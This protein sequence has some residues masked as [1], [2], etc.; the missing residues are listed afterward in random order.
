MPSVEP[1]G[2]YA[3]GGRCDTSRTV[4][5]RHLVPTWWPTPAGCDGL[6]CF[7]TVA[8]DRDW[9]GAPDDT[10]VD[11]DQSESVGSAPA[12]QFNAG[13][14]QPLPSNLSGGRQLPCER[15]D[16]PGRRRTPA[17]RGYSRACERADFEVRSPV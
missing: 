17:P 3:T 9:S 7:R 4:R 13:V 12:A 14:D 16:A 10:G 1:D 8:L 11:I 5:S 15:S 6:K 2:F